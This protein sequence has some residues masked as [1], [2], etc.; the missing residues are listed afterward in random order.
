[1]DLQT[2]LPVKIALTLVKAQIQQDIKNTYRE[3]LK[4]SQYVCPPKIKTFH[5]V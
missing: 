3:L 1:M 4:L 2:A 5:K